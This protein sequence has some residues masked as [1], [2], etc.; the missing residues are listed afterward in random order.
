MLV[1]GKFGTEVSVGEVAQLGLKL[2]STIREPFAVGMDARAGS[3][4]L[5]M[6]VIAGLTASGCNVANLGYVPAPVIARVAREEGMWGVHISADPYPPEYVGMSI[7]NPGGRAWEGKLAEALNGAGVGRVA[8]VDLVPD[9]MVQVLARHEL[10]KF[11]VVVDCAN[12][13]CGNIVPAILRAAGSRVFEINSA[14]SPFPSRP[15]YPVRSSITDLMYMTLRKR[16]DIGMG[17]D[18]SGKRAVFT[19]GRV[20]VSSSKAMG[21]I[22]KERGYRRAVAD[23][24]AS[25][26]LDY[27]GSV[28]RVPASEVKVGEALETRGYVIGGGTMGVIF[29]E[30]SFAPDAIYLALELL[31]VMSDTGENLRSLV[32]KLP[33]SYEDAEMVK[34]DVRRTLETARKELSDYDVDLRDGVKALMDEGW[35]W[36]KPMRDFVLVAAEA[37]TE[38]GLKKFMEMGRKFVKK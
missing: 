12:G 35:L 11:E 2:G 21:I 34:A 18:G 9:Y 1:L 25:F 30:W 23:I 27:I 5:H 32:D 4:P 22:M 29:S 24:G 20:L 38:R 3:A 6:A 19:D 7:Y 26:V 28:E 37:E 36:I 14:M 8:N 33:E 10:E 13:P 15:Y 16:A 17:F 31:Q